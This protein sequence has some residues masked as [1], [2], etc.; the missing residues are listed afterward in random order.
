LRA[1]LDKLRSRFFADN[2]P[3]LHSSGNAE[4]ARALRR[5]IQEFRKILAPYIG[6]DKKP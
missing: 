4:E 5:E 1:R 6:K 3:E 2:G